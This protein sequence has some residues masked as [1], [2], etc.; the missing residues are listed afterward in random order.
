[1]KA[2]VSRAVYPV[3]RV[4]VKR[5]SNIYRGFFLRWSRS[6]FLQKR[7]ISYNGL[8]VIVVVVAVVV[9]VVIVVDEFYR[10]AW[11]S[12]FCWTQVFPAKFIVE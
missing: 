3:T 12:R 2:V 8:V 7:L 5:V 6:S 10:R 9:V 4:P 1:M 11:Q